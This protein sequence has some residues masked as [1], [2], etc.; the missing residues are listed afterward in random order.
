[1]LKCFFK[2]KEIFVIHDITLVY[3]KDIRWYSAYK[4]LIFVI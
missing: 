2:I 3:R 1:M 4:H